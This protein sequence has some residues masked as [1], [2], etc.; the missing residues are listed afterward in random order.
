MSGWPGSG[1]RLFDEAEFLSPHGL[2][3][4]SAYHSEH[5]YEIDTDGVQA[6]IDYEPAES[7]TFSPA[8]APVPVST[9]SPP[10]PPYLRLG[11][12]PSARRVRSP[13]WGRAGCRCSPREP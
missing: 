3:A 6:T 12:A 7:T 10:G 13:H 1:T 2:R 8:S 9:R 4:L 11:S 5:P